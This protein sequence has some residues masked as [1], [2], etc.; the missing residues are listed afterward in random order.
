MSTIASLF[1]IIDLPWWAVPDRSLA[2]LTNGSSRK[3]LALLQNRVG[4]RWFQ[5]FA[6]TLK[7]LAKEEIIPNG[8]NPFLFIGLPVV[9]LAGPLTAAL[10]VPMAG[11]AP[12]ASLPGD[13]IVVLLPAQPAHLVH[14]PGRHQ[15][16][17]PFL[18]DRGYPHSDPGVFIRSAL[19]AG[20]SGS[21]GSRWK[22]ADQRHHGVCRAS[23]G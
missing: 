19:P 4:P 21:S 7:L 18:A 16:D 3:L 6:D 17:Q 20:A 23:T 12:A 1:A 9:A 5:P 14:G 15:Y 8:A 22:L 11:F 10:Y 2:W 13:L